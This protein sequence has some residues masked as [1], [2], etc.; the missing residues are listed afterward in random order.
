MSKSAEEN[1]QSKNRNRSVKEIIESRSAN[2]VR[3]TA[4]SKMHD[5][6][7][8]SNPRKEKETEEEYKG[9]QQI[10]MYKTD[11]NFRQNGSGKKS[12]RRKTRSR[13][14]RRYRK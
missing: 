6:W 3:D 2:P 14:T 8:K 1:I 10:Y 12:K 5:T 7:R 13:K 9:R 4:V 11:L